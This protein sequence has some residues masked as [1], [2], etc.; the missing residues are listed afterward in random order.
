[1]LHELIDIQAKVDFPVYFKANGG[2]FKEVKTTLGH[3][4]IVRQYANHSEIAR[5]VKE[6]SVAIFEEATDK[7]ANDVTYGDKIDPVKLVFEFNGKRYK[8][9]N[10][11]IQHLTVENVT[12]KNQKPGPGK[13]SVRT[14]EEL[15]EGM[16][17]VATSRFFK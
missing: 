7:G 2:M 8:V 6:K 4:F 1:M 3:R 16:V 12:F 11:Y 5:L 17:P 15:Q 9:T 10:A 14:F 13:R